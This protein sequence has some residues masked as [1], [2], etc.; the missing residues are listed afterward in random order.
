MTFGKTRLELKVGIFAF[1]G[2][3]ILAVFVLSIGKFRTLTKGYE[4]SFIYN[5]VNGVKIGAP[6]RFAG[7]DSGEVKRIHL[8][9]VPEEKRSKVEVVVWVRSE[10]Q[11]PRDSTAWINTLGLLG[12][13]YVEIM[14]GKDYLN[15]M[16]AHEKMIGVDPL[17]MH[18]M[19]R[20]AK[21]VV[22][23]MNECIIKI[24]NKEGTI[25]KLIFDDSIY[26]NLEEFTSDIK[27]YPWKLFIKTKEK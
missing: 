9:L 5:F 14:P 27:K 13:K 1:F 12:E 2:M 7:F 4:V 18:E 25:G 23:N 16:V 20:L 6:V 24:K 10:V 17:P 15:C 8:F 22:D 11:I 21:G 26:N 19:V 3:V